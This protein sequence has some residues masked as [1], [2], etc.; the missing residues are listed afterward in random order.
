MLRDAVIRV[1]NIGVKQGWAASL[2]SPLFELVWNEY[3]EKLSWWT[4]ICKETIPIIVN[5]PQSKNYW[6]LMGGKW[7]LVEKL[8]LERALW[9][10]LNLNKDRNESDERLIELRDSLLPWLQPMLWQRMQDRPVKQNI[11]YEQHKSEMMSGTFS[12]DDSTVDVIE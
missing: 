6:M 9:I 7:D 10:L 3:I 4:G 2:T 12:L 11:M 5:E 8:T 1:A